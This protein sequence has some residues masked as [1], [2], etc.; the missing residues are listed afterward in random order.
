ML[1]ISLRG[2]TIEFIPLLASRT[3]NRGLNHQIY[4]SLAQS[5][6]SVILGSEPTEYRCIFTRKTYALR[7]RVNPRYHTQRRIRAVNEQRRTRTIIHNHTLLSPTLRLT[8]T[9]KCTRDNSNSY[10]VTL[11]TRNTLCTQ[12][13][14]TLLTAE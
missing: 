3:S 10:L 11:D 13:V 14:H 12:R 6:T 1:M 9:I 4:G 2:R 8:T 7:L 5:T